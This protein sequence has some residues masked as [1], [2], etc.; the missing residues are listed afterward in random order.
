M[1]QQ[2]DCCIKLLNPQSLNNLFD[3]WVYLIQLS[4]SMQQFHLILLVFSAI[5]N[6]YF[7]ILIFYS[8][9]ECIQVNLGWLPI[10]AAAHVL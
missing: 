8:S 4:D 7:K 1:R 5:P 2:W 10:Y 6:L 9:S 3:L